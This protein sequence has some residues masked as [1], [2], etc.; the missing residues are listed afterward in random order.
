MVGGG[1][2]GQPLGATLPPGLP[3]LGP[4]LLVGCPLSGA[5][6]SWDSERLSR[7][8]LLC[9]HTSLGRARPGLAGAAGWI[10]ALLPS[11]DSMNL[12]LCLQG[13]EFRYASASLPESL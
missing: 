1:R 8:G 2:R 4:S 10:P 9:P 13:K 7:G 5:S 11:W 6:W 3:G 12:L